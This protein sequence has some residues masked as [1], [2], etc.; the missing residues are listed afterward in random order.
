MH[1]TQRAPD[2]RQ[3]APGL[4]WWESARFQAVGVTGAGSAKLALSRP[5]HQRVTQAVNC[6]NIRYTSCRLE[7]SKTR[8]NLAFF[9]GLYV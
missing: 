5:A 3:S 1:L 9:H 2:L 7:S 4:A 6:N 8:L